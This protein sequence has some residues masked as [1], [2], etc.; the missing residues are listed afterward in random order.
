MPNPQEKGSN[1][2]NVWARTEPE[3]GRFSP[4]RQSFQ[5]NENNDRVQFDSDG[6]EFIYESDENG[7]YDEETISYT[8]TLSICLK[9]VTEDGDA[10]LTKNLLDVLAKL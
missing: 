1:I 3:G 7:N 8:D 10:E 9:T 6:R 2:T 4:P 5:P